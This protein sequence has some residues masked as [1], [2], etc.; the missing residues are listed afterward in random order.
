MRCSTYPT[1]ITRLISYVLYGLFIMDLNLRSIKTNNWSANNLQKKNMPPQWVV[2]L[3]LRYSVM[4]LVSGYPFWQL[5]IDHN[6]DVHQ[7]VHCLGHLAS[8][9][10]SL[11]ENSHSEPAYYCSHTIKWHIG[12]F[13]GVRERN[14]RWGT[15]CFSSPP[16]R[17]PPPPSTL[18]KPDAR[19]ALQALQFIWRK[20]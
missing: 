3:S 5:S 13:L 8:N 12:N 15:A 19:A 4:A 10:R 6:L 2:H 18:E 16:F 9:T 20:W 17:S 14:R 1:L 7:V 11:L